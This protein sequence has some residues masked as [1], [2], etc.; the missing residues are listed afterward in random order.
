MTTGLIV[1][2]TV[3]GLLVST[4]SVT[5]YVNEAEPEKP[6]VPVTPT[7]QTPEPSQEAAVVTRTLVSCNTDAAVAESPSASV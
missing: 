1:I 2:D 6:V 3:A 7:V 5:V 4:P